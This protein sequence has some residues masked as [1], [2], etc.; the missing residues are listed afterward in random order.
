MF[1]PHPPGAWTCTV[2]VHDFEMGPGWMPEC[3]SVWVS[4]GLQQ[5]ELLTVRLE[6]VIQQ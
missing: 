3:S 4:L 6:S 5:L 1:F 2:T